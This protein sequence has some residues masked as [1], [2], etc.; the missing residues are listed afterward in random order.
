MTQDYFS[1]PMAE[2]IELYHLRVHAAPHDDDKRE[3]V[4]VLSGRP[5]SLHC[6]TPERSFELSGCCVCARVQ[7]R[8]RVYYSLTESASRIRVQNKNFPRTSDSIE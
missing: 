4:L 2:D 5:I 7:V 1:F 6:D 8:A 3:G